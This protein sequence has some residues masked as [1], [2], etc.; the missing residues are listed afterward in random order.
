MG[1]AKRRMNP[2]VVNHVNRNLVVLLTKMVMKAV[3]SYYHHGN[4]KTEIDY[5][6]DGLVLKQHYQHLPG[7]SVIHCGMDIDVDSIGLGGFK[8]KSIENLTLS[9]W[10]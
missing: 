9:A 4:P 10:D 3:P 8:L 6:K 5:T 2:R 1:C 7:H